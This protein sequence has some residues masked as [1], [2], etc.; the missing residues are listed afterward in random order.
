MNLISTLVILDQR[1]KQIQEPCVEDCRE[2]NEQLLQILQD[3]V[4][5]LKEAYSVLEPGKE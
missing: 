5:K 1:P 3:D 2:I 4:A